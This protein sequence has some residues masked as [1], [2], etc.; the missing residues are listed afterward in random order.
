MDCIAH[1][2]FA[3]ANPENTIAAVRRARR[4]ADWIEVDV[5]RCGSGELVVIHDRTVDRVTDASGPV[6]SHDRDTLAGLDVLGSG[7]G[8]PTLRSVLGAVP[9]GVGLDLELKERGLAADTA[10]ALDGWPGRAVVSS[11]DPATLESLREVSTLPTALIGDEDAHGLVRTA[12][13]IGCRAVCAAHA[14]CT[15]TLVDR[16]HAAGLSVYAWTVRDRETATACREDGVD[17]LIADDPAV[18]VE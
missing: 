7:E 1:R 5:R 15:P 14:L 9:P 16:A 4:S 10:A 2:G 3:S 8:V 12:A 13:S 18:C 17:G 11:F 6:A